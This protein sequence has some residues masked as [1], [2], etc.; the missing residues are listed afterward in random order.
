MSSGGKGDDP[1]D[2]MHECASHLDRW[3][4]HHIHMG[5]GVIDAGHR[6]RGYR[7]L[8]WTSSQLYVR[9][10]YD[11]IAHEKCLIMMRFIVAWLNDS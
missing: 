5:T 2:R 3:F 8:L 4:T 9:C 6:L 7:L 11:R 1:S 10:D